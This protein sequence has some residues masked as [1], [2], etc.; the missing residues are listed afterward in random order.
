MTQFYISQLPVLPLLLWETPP[1]LDLI[2]AQEDPL[3]SRPV[4]RYPMAASAWP[5][6]ALRRPASLG[7]AVACDALTPD[8]VALDIDL[9]RQE[10]R[11]DPFQALVDTKAA[12]RVVA[13]DWP[14]R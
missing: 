1:G 5:L 12:Y 13:G 7:L 14:G 11:R 6:R 10:D 3:L 4:R 2:L 9:L 8:H